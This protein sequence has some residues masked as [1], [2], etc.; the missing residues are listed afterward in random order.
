MDRAAGTVRANLAVRFAADPNVQIANRHGVLQ[1]GCTFVGERVIGC[2]QGAKNSLTYNYLV[3]PK[4]FR[5]ER[6]SARL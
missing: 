5:R 6:V 4:T 2:I 3:S 1:Q